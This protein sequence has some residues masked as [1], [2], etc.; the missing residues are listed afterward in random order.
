MQVLLRFSLDTENIGDE[1][2]NFKKTLTFDAAF[3]RAN[4]F[5][6]VMT[7]FGEVDEDSE[8]AIWTRSLI[9]EYVQVAECI[10]DGFVVVFIGV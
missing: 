9:D 6:R 2:T 5:R 3:N 10:F 1:K 8:E 7:G 4:T